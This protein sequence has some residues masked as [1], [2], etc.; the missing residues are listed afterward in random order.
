M[1][2]GMNDRQIVDLSQKLKAL[3]EEKKKEFFDSITPSEAIELMYH[4][5]FGLR[6][7]QLV[8]WED[9]KPIVLFLA[10]RGLRQIPYFNSNY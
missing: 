10:G 3:P 1:I 5:S 4:P 6:P 2:K 7:N 8:E 9:G